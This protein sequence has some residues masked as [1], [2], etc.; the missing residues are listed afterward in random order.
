M[1]PMDG[2]NY[3]VAM[4]A[5]HFW[6]PYRFLDE[7]TFIFSDW[8][9]SMRGVSA[10]LIVLFFL[11]E[12]IRRQRASLESGE[13]H[14][15]GL[16]VWTALLSVFLVSANAYWYGT[17]TLVEVGSSI[18]R[19]VDNAA[20]DALDME[21]SNLLKGILKST[22]NPVSFFTALLELM[23][24]IGFLTLVSYWLVVA[25]LFA[26][27]LLQ[28]LYVAVFVLLGPILVPFALWEPTRMVA[29]KWL[30]SLLGASFIS[31]FGI[32]AYT[33]ISVSGI[34]TNLA[35]AGENHVLSLVYSFTTLAFLIAVPWVSFR[36]FGALSPS[37]SEGVALAMRTLQ[38]LKLPVK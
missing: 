16:V 33:A 23:T 24:P 14:V 11:L 8:L 38:R 4:L 15:L 18:G 32:V 27:P 28:S 37:V 20:M 6:K 3:L 26:I 7:G 25:L 17:H 29:K 34:L 30:L 10:A 35:E 36:M 12:Y 1:T 2:L 19:A 9:H 22:Q 21:V 13:F 31:V 5:G